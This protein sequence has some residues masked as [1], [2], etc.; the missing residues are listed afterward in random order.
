V[1]QSA[2]FLFLNATNQAQYGMH[3]GHDC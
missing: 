3:Y 1:P 2:R